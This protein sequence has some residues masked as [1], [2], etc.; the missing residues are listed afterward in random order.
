M[1]TYIRAQ[2]KETKDYSNRAIASLKKTPPKDDVDA[3][4]KVKECLKE[5]EAKKTS[6]ELGTDSNRAALMYF[7]HKGSPVDKLVAELDVAANLWTDVVKQS[8]LTANSIVPLVKTWSVQISEQIEAYSKEMSNKLKAFKTRRFWADDLTPAEAQEAI[9]EA[10]KF[11]QAETEELAKKTSLCKTFDF[12]HL[13]KSAKEVVDEMTQDLTEMKKLWVCFDTLQKFVRESKEVLWREMNIDDLDEQA[14]NQVK[15]VKNMHKC[16][17][18]SSAYKAA[19][20]MS[21]DFLNTIPLV[22]LLAAKCMRDRHWTALKVVTK[23]DFTPPYEDPDMLL[24][25]ILNLGL[26]EFTGDV[27]DICDQAAK[28]LKIENSLK[29]LNERWQTVEWLMEHYKDTD[30]PLLKMSEE[31]FESLEADQLTVQGMLASRFVKQFETEA[32]S[33]SIHKLYYFSRF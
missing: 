24:G 27:E 23:K 17:R 10:E 4:I 21:K 14:K 25:G 5:C 33:V 6:I 29:T 3:L 28:E 26:H 19:D 7:K 11:L 20:K 16:V 2:V 1:M 8:P 15:Y 12:P 30:I 32:Q 22:S 31:D 9:T 13:V 18:W